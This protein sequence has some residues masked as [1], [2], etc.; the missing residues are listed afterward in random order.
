MGT[1]RPFGGLS[2]ASSELNPVSGCDDAQ[3]RID[4]V[5]GLHDKPY[6]GNLSHREKRDRFP[7][8]CMNI[9]SLNRKEGLRAV[10]E[11]PWKLGRHGPG[12]LSMRKSVCATTLRLLFP[13]S[14]IVISAWLM[15]KN[16]PPHSPEQ[17]LIIY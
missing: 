17:D 16:T 11:I 8:L 2:R 6:A 15:V 9:H 10:I 5:R 14:R 4:K 13:T 1:V 7:L 3:N 12:I